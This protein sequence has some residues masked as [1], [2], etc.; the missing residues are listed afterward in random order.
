MG[1]ENSTVAESMR[2]QVNQFYDTNMDENQ[3]DDWIKL[4]LYTTCQNKELLSKILARTRTLNTPQDV[5]DFV[6]AEELGK[7]NA[8]RL[9]GGKAT[10]AR[11]QGKKIICFICQK[12]GHI[13]SECKVDKAKLFCKYCKQ[14][15]VHNTNNK[16]P[17]FKKKGQDKKEDSNKKNDRRNHRNKVR[18]VK[19]KEDDDDPPE[20]EEEGDSDSGSSVSFIGSRVQWWPT[21]NGSEADSEEEL[22]SSQ[23]PEVFFLESEYESENGSSESGYYTPPNSPEGN[24]EDLITDDNDSRI[25][26]DEYL[27]QIPA[28]PALSSDTEPDLDSDDDDDIFDDDDDV[29]WTNNLL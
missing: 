28:M 9:L 19:G 24:S 22:E 1:G 17:E 29:P 25:S 8:D 7:L 10:A 2:R 11:M 15:G 5:I 12:P 18:T 23:E 6:D 27:D 4:L 14:K 3:T 20:D 26:E 13:K 16:C 21:D